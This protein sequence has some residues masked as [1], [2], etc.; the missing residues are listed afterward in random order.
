MMGMRAL[1]WMSLPGLDLSAGTITLPLWAA[2]AAAGLVV[3]FLIVAI[4]RAG[5]V[6]SL[7]CVVGLGLVAVAVVTAVNLVNRQDRAEERRSLERRLTALT[8]GAIA[9]GSPLSCLDA[10][11]GEAVEGS[12]EKT[13]FASPESVAAATAFVGARLSLLIDGLDFA[14]RIDP[15]YENA[16]VGLRRGIEADR[17]GFVAQ[18]L[19]SRDGCTPGKC[20]TFQWLRDA[21]R[22]RANLNERTFESLVARNSSG[23]PARTRSTT[24]VAAAPAAAPPS[25][26]PSSGITF[27]SAASIPPVS[28]MNNEPAATA[29]P[30]PPTPPVASAPAATPPARRPA[31][32]A[33]QPA[34]TAQPRTQPTTAPPVQLGPPAAASAGTQP[35]TQ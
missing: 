27:P 7:G 31:P 15:N 30:P 19:A 5:L 21:T 2:G 18:V 3:L 32:A 35:R 14:N 9:P 1:D 22:I 13:M 10:N 25:S 17:F 24:P 33:A 34:R 28:I 23:W 6:V 26:A 29:A 12:C 11:V 8:V 20:D 4:F 16:L